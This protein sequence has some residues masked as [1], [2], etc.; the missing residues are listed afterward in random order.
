MTTTT[1][2]LEPVGEVTADSRSRIAFE[3]SG[4]WRRILEQSRVADHASE[5]FGFAGDEP[6]T[7]QIAP[8][9]PT[10]PGPDR[11]VIG[12]DSANHSGARCQ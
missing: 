4:P 10:F 6:R 8:H 9:P 2:Y 12:V 7:G 11:L 5:P 1:S 3:R